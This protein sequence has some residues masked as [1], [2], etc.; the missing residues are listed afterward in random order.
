MDWRS[1][2]KKRGMTAREYWESLNSDPALIPPEESLMGSA[3]GRYRE[4]N[5]TL[6]FSDE[7]RKEI[8]DRTKGLHSTFDETTSYDIEIVTTKR[9]IRHE[10]L[11]DES[12]DR[13]DGI[14]L[15]AR[16][17]DLDSLKNKQITKRSLLNLVI[18]HAEYH[19]PMNRLGKMFTPDIFSSSNISRWLGDSAYKHLP[20]Y[21]YYTDAIA[22]ADIINV[23]DTNTFVVEMSE[24]ARQDLLIADSDMNNEAWLKYLEQIKQKYSDKN[25][26]DFVTPVAKRIGRV[27]SYAS[28]KGGKKKIN[29]TTVIGRSNPNDSRST[30]YFYRTHFGQAGNLISRIF[31]PRDSTTKQQVKLIIQCD[32]SQ[33]NNI[34]K[35]LKETIIATY[36]GCGDHARRPFDRY[37]QE[38]ENLAY[39]MLI[40]FFYIY[41]VER[42]IFAG[43]LTADRVLNLRNEAKKYW[44]IILS[45]CTNVVEG[46]QDF[47]ALNRIHHSSS[48]LLKGC[49]YIINHYEKCTRYMN[50]PRLRLTNGIAERKLRPEKLFVNSSKFS[51]SESGAIIKDI[52]RTSLNTCRAAGIDPAIY[53]AW[54]EDQ[55]YEDIERNPANYT[56]YAYALLLDNSKE[57]AKN[58]YYDQADIPSHSPA[59]LQ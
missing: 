6:R 19:V 34:E 59:S 26:H 15:S 52:H 22:K 49:Q 12:Q 2:A 21:L 16:K 28:Q 37:K 5:K 11:T 54:I 18:L 50:D 35:N 41:A 42:K 9:I 30:I 53:F 36:L 17:R 55:D 40:Q 32:C 23:D 43:L 3:L 56:P 44:D 48:N 29:L 7:E 33:Q 51:W 10:T 4:E 13:G 57:Y 45:V 47:R 27:A 1:K 39:F 58:P 25:Q 46:K 38:D 20:I 31:C 14:A 8:F 24:A